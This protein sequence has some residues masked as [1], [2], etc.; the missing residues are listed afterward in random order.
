M[1]ER[2]SCWKAIRCVVTRCA[3]TDPFRLPVKG[4]AGHGRF[5]ALCPPLGQVGVVGH[6]FHKFAETGGA[7][8]FHSSLRSISSGRRSSGAKTPDSTASWIEEYLG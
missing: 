6:L 8:Q 2:A 3:G 5:D 4:K 1:R 7:H